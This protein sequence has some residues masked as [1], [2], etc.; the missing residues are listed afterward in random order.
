MD[1][2]N[3]AEIRDKGVCLSVCAYPLG[4]GELYGILS[5]LQFSEAM[6]LKMNLD[7]IFST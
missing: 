1:S 6:I 5:S 3:W 2:A 4:V 7:Q